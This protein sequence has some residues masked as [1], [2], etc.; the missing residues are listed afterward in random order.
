MR[1]EAKLRKLNA[2]R[3]RMPHVTAAALAAILVAVQLQGVPEAHS[4]NAMRYARDLENNFQTDYGSI[5][6]QVEAVN[7]V[8]DKVSLQVANPF[9]LLWTAVSS[10]ASF[11]KFFRER[12]LAIP[13][14]PEKPWTLVLYSDE[15][16]PGNVFSCPNP[17]L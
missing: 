15:V 1:R 13:P 10:C 9:A 7:K 11:S 3:R 14:S 4:R 12:L 8:G 16:T 5:S 6:R 2:F 17:V